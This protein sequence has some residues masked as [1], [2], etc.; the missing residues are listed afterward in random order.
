M[1]KQLKGGAFV[2]PQV[3]GGVMRM[4][5]ARF[6]AQFRGLGWRLAC[7]QRARCPQL[8][9]CDQAILRAGMAE[10]APIKVDAWMPPLP[11]KTR[12]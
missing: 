3:Q 4:P 6:A 8:A 2:W 10:M 11:K 9:G 12:P 5:P 1:H 7:P